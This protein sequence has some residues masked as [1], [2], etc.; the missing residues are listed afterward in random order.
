MQIGSVGSN[1]RF[2]GVEDVQPKPFRRQASGLANTT[3]A[4]C[5]LYDL[6][7]QLIYIFAAMGARSEGAVCRKNRCE[8]ALKAGVVTHLFYRCSKAC[9]TRKFT[10][11]K[12]SKNTVGRKSQSKQCKCTGAS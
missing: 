12:Q 7:D 5:G 9:G 11:A 6:F 2:V 8:A 4:A 3:A 1:G 10:L